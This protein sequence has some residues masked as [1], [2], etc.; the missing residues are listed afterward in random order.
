M[1]RSVRDRGLLAAASV[2]LLVVGACAPAPAPGSGSSAAPVAEQ[3]PSAPKSIT[4][5]L[6]VEPP[7]VFFITGQA[8]GGGK[9]TQYVFHDDLYVELA[10]E[11]YTPQLAL[12]IPSVDK[13]TWRVNA[14]GTMDTTWKLRPNVVWHD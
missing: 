12:E 14:D 2:L 3:R 4:M 13:G 8:G 7:G 6:L 10:Y 5:A 1:E 11:Q 9:D